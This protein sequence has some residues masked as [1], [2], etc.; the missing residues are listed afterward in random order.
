MSVLILINMQCAFYP[1]IFLTFVFLAGCTSIRNREALDPLMGRFRESNPASIRVDG[2]YWKETSVSSSGK[3]FKA[4]HAIAFFRGGH[5]MNFPVVPS[6]FYRERDSLPDSLNTI[7]RARKNFKK[8]LNSLIATTRGFDGWGR[9]H[10]KSDTLIMGW[11]SSEGYGF[12]FF[13]QS[14]VAGVQYG[15]VI[16]DSALEIDSGTYNFT[17]MSITVDTDSLRLSHP[18]F[19]GKRFPG[20][21]WGW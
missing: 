8:S 3:P 14:L 15:R 12:P 11:L 6:I 4:I 18:R 19:N 13:N 7:E 2:Y 9:Y 17:P 16:S 10:V 21:F 1:F 5:L 20:F